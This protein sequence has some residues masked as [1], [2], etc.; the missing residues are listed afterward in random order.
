MQGVRRHDGQ[1]GADDDD[2]KEPVS[3][4][5]YVRGLDAEPMVKTPTSAGAMAGRA[6]GFARPTRYGPFRFFRF[7]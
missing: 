5:A 4:R 7:A 1:L 2:A 6:F 3:C